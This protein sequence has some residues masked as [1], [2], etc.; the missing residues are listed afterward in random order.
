MNDEP[1]IPSRVL[2]YDGYCGMCDASVQ[3]VLAHD[4]EG[5]FHMAALQGE[6]AKGILARHPELPDRLDSM[7]VVER[8]EGG[9]VVR[10]ESRAVLRLLVLL[11]WPWRVFG[12][13]YLVP[14]M[15]AD[16]LYRFV[17]RHRL[18]VLGKR[19]ACRIPTEAEANRFLP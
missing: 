18:K 3:W 19:D 10:W 6:T 7:L 1:S 2:V 4:P 9:E 13:L 16:P 8:D 15:I 17:A 14:K 11:G 5:R 12:L